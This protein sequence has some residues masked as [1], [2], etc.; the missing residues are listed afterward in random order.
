MAT[1]K[2]ENNKKTLKTS[3]IS[4]EKNEMLELYKKMFLIRQFELACGEN[5]TKG[6]IRGFLHLY[7]G[8]EATAVGSISNLIDEDYIVTHYRDHGHAIAR[9]LDINRSMAELFGK[10]TGLSKGK[11]G[12]MH[13]F[14]SG[15]KFMGGHAIVGGQFPLA[16]GLALACQY[17]K[18]GG[19]V[20]CFFGDGSTNQGTYHE[21]L[22]LASVWKLPILFILENNKYGMGSS[23]DRVRAGGEDFYTA[24]STYDIPA[25]QVNGMD[26]LAVKEATKIAIE[27]VRHNG[28]PFYLECKTFR[29]VGHSLAD[30]Q[31]YRKTNEIKEW[32]KQDPIVRFPE[33][34]VSAGIA[35]KKDLDKIHNEVNITV[36]ESV[37]FADS[38]SEPKN[39]EVYNDIYK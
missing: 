8:Q 36:K 20:V 14:D 35:T 24:A 10:S 6:N 1:L 29:F 25:A 16:T 4:L 15:K 9:G 2:R 31:K 7:I 12:S 30:G 33:W 38:S 19:L 17:K 21:T 18:T 28:G 11:G 37:E 5:Y 22:N 13:L 32:E 26:V 27:K 34:L 39:S 23:I 3:K